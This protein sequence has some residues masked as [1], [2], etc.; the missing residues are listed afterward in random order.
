MD[1]YGTKQIR[2][3][4]LLGHGGAGKTTVAEAL[5]YLTGVTKRMGKV[6]DGNT[7][8]DYDKEEIKRQFSISTTM[9]PLEYEGAEGKIKIN[10]LDTPGY[11]DFVGEVEEAVSV[12]DA[13]IIVVNCKAGIEVGTEKAWELCEEYRLPRMFFVTNM[14][15]DH[16]SFRELILKLEK[17]FGRK[18]A[19]FQV[20]IRENEKFVGFVNV[21]KMAGRRFTNFSDYEECEIPE[22]T[23]KNL[24]IIRDALIE[25]VAE[26]SEEYMERYFAGEEFTQDEIYTAVQTHVWQG[27]IVPVFMGSG[28]NCQGFQALLN[29]IDRYFPSPDIGECIGVDVSTGE[30]F[31]AKYN[32]EVSLSAR[33]FKTVVDPFIGKYSLMKICTGILKPDS[34]IYNVNKDAEEKVAKVY[35]L[36]GKDVI[37][38]PELK[39]GDIGAVAKLNVTQTGDTIALR[40]APIV[41]HKPKIST[42]YTYMRYAAKTKGD[43]DKISSALSKMMEE[44]LT[45]RAVNDVENRQS[46]LYGIGDQ[47]LEVTVSKLLG[48]YKVEVE[49]SK[50]KIAF[51]ETIRKKVTAPGRYKKQSGGHGQFGDVKMEFEPSGDLETPYVFEE[52]VFGGAVPKNYFPAVEKGIQECCQKGPLA[53]YPVV[54]IK[55]VLVDGSYHPVDSSE[56]AFKM[57]ATLAFK[58][59]FMEAGP[60]LLEP[61]ASVKVVVPDKFTGDVMGDLNRRRGRVLGMNSLH[62]GK[63]EIVA[64]VPMSE[65]FGYNT[66]LRSMTG[67]IGV[68]SYEFSRYEQAPGDIQ[69]KEVEA[70]AASLEQGE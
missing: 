43:E 30:R 32:E 61:I 45:L 2:N 60:V 31:T 3:V 68:Y 56:M 57:A 51:R 48:R 50:P 15:D 53:G 20:P 24:G 25:A 64:D 59:G 66:D 27:D 29:A 16:A 38:V 28:I 46:L 65:M 47:Q 58:K 63:Q 49:L 19:P 54:G 7:I 4:V 13:A 55:A 12:A 39:A 35:V 6:S 52:R 14:D 22:Y 21:V 11:F 62:G 37:E 40:T 70:R 9:I 41:Y 34:T 36:R 5:A 69:K 17:R 8:S 23:K 26:T 10:L 67:G 18:I 1:V 44:D 33:V 42:P